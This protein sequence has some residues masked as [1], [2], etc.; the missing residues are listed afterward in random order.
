[1]SNTTLAEKGGR[2]L[3]HA[4]WMAFI[5]LGGFVWGAYVKVDPALFTAFVSAL[6]VQSGA[7]IWGNVQVHKAQATVD[8]AVAESGGTVTNEKG[9]D[10]GAD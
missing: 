6:A 9:D 7:F 4:R 5:L 10:N 1:M 2:K 3:S 8:V